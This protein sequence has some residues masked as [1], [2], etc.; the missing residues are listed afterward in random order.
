MPNPPSLGANTVRMLEALCFSKRE[1]LST[2]PACRND[3]ACP[4]PLHSEGVRACCTSSAAA[5]SQRRAVNMDCD[6]SASAV[7]S[8]DRPDRLHTSS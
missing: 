5:A 2:P 6:S 3:K 4:E 1:S 7:A 8:G